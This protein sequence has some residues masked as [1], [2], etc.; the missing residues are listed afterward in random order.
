MITVSGSDRAPGSCGSRG[1][2][3]LLGDSGGLGSSGDSHRSHSSA[4]TELRR[5]ESSPKTRRPA[6]PAISQKAGSITQIQ[7]HKEPDTPFL[8]AMTAYN[9]LRIARLELQSG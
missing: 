6:L 4:T 5:R 1:N 8:L 3:P 9:L 2:R 7:L